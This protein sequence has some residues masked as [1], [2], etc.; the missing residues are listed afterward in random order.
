[1]YVD[2]VKLFVKKE[3]EQETLIQEVR[4]CCD[5]IGTEFGKEICAM[6]IMRS[7]K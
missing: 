4:I 7:G 5:N 1:M 6:L 2:D 3:K